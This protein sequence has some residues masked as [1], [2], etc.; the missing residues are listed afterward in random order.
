MPTARSGVRPEVSV[1]YR[2]IGELKLDPRNARIHSAAQVRQL[3]ASIEAFGRAYE[4][5]EPR[6]AMDAFLK[7]RRDTQT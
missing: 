3:A 7:G 5:D 6:Q 2:T 1:S 4:S